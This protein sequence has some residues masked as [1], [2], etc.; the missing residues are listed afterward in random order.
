MLAECADIHVASHHLTDSLEKM[1]RLGNL[2]SM[3]LGPEYLSTRQGP[4][5][6]KL[7]YL[8][9]W[10]AISLANEVF[11]HNG[12]SSSVKDISIDFVGGW[13]GRVVETC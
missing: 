3:R 12:W 2:L 9:G 10:R 11:G 1:Q 6:S 4:G 5:G 8:E 7:T 13:N